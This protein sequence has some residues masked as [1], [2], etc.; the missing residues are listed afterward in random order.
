[1]LEPGELTVVTNTGD[2]DEF[3]GLL[4][5]P[6]T[7]AVLYRLAGIFNESAGWGVRDETFHA[8]D[9]LR[10]LGFDAW[11]GLGDRDLGTHLARESLMRAGM[12]PS[13]AA[14]ELGRR[15]GLSSRVVPVTDDRVRTYFHT[16]AGRLSFQEYFVRD[17]LQPE[18]EA[19]EFEGLEQASPAAAVAAALAEADLVVIGPSNP[20]ISTGPVLGVLRGIARPERTVAVSPIVAG[21]ALKGPTVPMMRLLGVSADAAGV[22]RAYRAHARGFV[23]DGL[24]AS[25]AGEI[26]GLGYRVTVADTVMRDAASRRALAEAVLK[27]L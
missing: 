19:V 26:S 10:R 7:D 24:D 23:L 3:H 16:R 18:L 21:Q 1:M 5:C 2:D 6:D 8:Q 12:T 13:E 14:L 17:R 15:L 20:L 25:S 4:V 9:T 22:A 11:F 27:S